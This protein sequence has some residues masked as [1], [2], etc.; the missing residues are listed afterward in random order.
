MWRNPIFLLSLLVSS[1]ERPS[2]RGRRGQ[3]GQQG[4]EGRSRDSEDSE[5]SPAQGGSAHESRHHLDII[6]P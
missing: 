5:D 1:F 6:L 2:L 3:R 4:R